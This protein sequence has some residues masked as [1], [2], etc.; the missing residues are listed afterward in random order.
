MPILAVSS[1]FSKFKAMCLKM[2]KFSAPLPLRILDSSSRKA[3]SN[4]QCNEVSIP[5]CSR[6]APNKLFAVSS[7]LLI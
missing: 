7:A 5:Q 4:L 3:M 2:A 6:L 1:L